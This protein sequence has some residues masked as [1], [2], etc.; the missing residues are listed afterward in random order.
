[1]NPLRSDLDW[2]ITPERFEIRKST[3]SYLMKGYGS[4]LNE[5]GTPQC[6][7]GDIYGCADTWVS[8]GNSTTE[9]IDEFFLEYCAASAELR[10]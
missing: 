2:R 10:Q 6:R 3:L 8:Q 1:M 4:K 9:G 5:D 7:S